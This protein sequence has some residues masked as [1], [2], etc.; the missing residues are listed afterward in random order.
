MNAGGWGREE[1]L[2]L[3]RCYRRQ[4]WMAGDRVKLMNVVEKRSETY[5]VEHKP[6]ANWISYAVKKVANKIIK[7]QCMINTSRVAPL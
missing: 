5:L 7:A 2:D 6:Y 4:K 3:W 1:E